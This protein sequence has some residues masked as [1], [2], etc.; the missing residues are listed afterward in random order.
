[1]VRRLGGEGTR[2]GWCGRGRGEAGAAGDA[3]RL[4]RRLGGGGSAAAGRQGRRGGWAAGE[5]P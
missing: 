5:E 1:M 2:R 3:A 4:V